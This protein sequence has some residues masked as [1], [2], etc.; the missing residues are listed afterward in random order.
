MITGGAPW[1]CPGRHFATTE[2][3]VFVALMIA[4]YDLRPAEQ[5]AKGIDDA[6]WPPLPTQFSNNLATSVI[7]PDWDIKI[8]I[9]TRK[10]ID[11]NTKWVLK[12]SEGGGSFPLPV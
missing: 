10:G 12:L 1:L 6:A 3:L 7:P 8:N 5:V 11:T 4:R 9:R 2:I